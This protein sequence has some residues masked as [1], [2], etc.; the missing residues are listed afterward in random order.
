MSPTEAIQ[1]TALEQSLWCRAQLETFIFGLSRQFSVAIQSYRLDVIQ[2]IL[3][4]GAIE[5]TP[6]AWDRRYVY[7]DDGV[8]RTTCGFARDVF[9]HFVRMRRDG[10]EFFLGAACIARC[11]HESNPVVQGFLAEQIAISTINSRHL[12]MYR[13]Q[14][15][16][17]KMT[18]TYFSD[19]D[20]LVNPL[21]FSADPSHHFLLAAFNYAHIDSLVR[22]LSTR[23]AKIAHIYAIQY[24]KMPVA[25]HIKSLDFFDGSHKRWQEDLKNYTIYWHFVWVLTEEHRD[26]H[27]E[28]L[29]KK[30]D[31]LVSAKSQGRSQS[32]RTKSKLQWPI[33]KRKDYHM[34]EGDEIHAG[35][36]NKI[37][38]VNFMEW[39]YSYSDINS[40][41][42]F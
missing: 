36:E 34:P 11:L 42:I 30:Q 17:P 16:T 28:T 32:V 2:R 1:R 10:N 14:E 5:C 38:G 19:S 33:K 4:Q 37:H 24:T 13:R 20:D 21:V 39:V 7:D 25:S 6:D 29:C 27:R 15:R 12:P 22:V 35:F 9:A 40:K 41:L 23:K 26:H 18:F 3:L 31:A 8:F